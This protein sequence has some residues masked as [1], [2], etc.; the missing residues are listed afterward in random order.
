MLVHFIVNIYTTECVYVIATDIVV[1][2]EGVGLTL[3]ILTHPL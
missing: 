2:R 1:M 3:P